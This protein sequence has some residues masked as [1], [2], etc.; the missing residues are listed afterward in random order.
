M[1]LFHFDSNFHLPILLLLIISLR[2]LFVKFDDGK[3][4]FCAIEENH[5]LLYHK[6]VAGK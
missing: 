1:V 4:K 5:T 3:N 2:H 6:P